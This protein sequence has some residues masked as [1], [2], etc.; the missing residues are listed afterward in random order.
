MKPR[1]SYLA[2]E[3]ISVA[4]ILFVVEGYILLNQIRNSVITDWITVLTPLTWINISIVNLFVF[5]RLLKSSSKLLIIKRYTYNKR[6]PILWILFSIAFFLIYSFVQGS[7]VLDFSGSMS[8]RFSVVDSLIGYGPTVIIILS[9]N[10][11]FILTPYTF[12]AAI[13]ISIFAGL[14]ITLIIILRALGYKLVLSPITGFT[15]ICP[16]C[17]LNPIIGF[18]SGYL[19]MASILTGIISTSIASTLYVLSTVLYIASLTF[20]WI[21]LIIISRKLGSCQPLN[22][23]ELGCR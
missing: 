10:L 16:T 15:V 18:L 23:A 12:A 4:Y 21:A 13:T 6:F 11:G 20:M 5:F 7:M 14:L 19:S 9:Q 2:I 1:F 17:M 8:P 22:T 3:T